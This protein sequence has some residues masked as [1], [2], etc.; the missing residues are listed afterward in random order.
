M[1][2]LIVNVQGVLPEAEERAI[3]KESTATVAKHEGQ[4]P[5]GWLGAGLSESAVIIASML[6]PVYR[7]Y[8]YAHVCCRTQISPALRL[9]VRVSF[10]ALKPLSRS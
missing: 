1:M 7:W 4:A 5:K 6:V 3:I 10:L 9:S 2:L 8:S